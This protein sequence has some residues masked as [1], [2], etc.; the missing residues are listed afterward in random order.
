[1]TKKTIA[2]PVVHEVPEDLRRALVSNPDLV[3][4][5]TDLTPLALNEWRCWTTIVKKPETRKE[6]YYQR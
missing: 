6:Y 5:W 2:D 4:R 3:N 1:M